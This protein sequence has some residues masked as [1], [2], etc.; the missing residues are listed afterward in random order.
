MYTYKSI[1]DCGGMQAIGEERVLEIDGIKLLM[2]QI[3][4]KRKENSS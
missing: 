3:W 2:L 1:L 4:R